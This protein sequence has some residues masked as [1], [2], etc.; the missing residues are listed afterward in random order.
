MQEQGKGRVAARLQPDRG[1]SECVLPQFCAQLRHLG[2]REFAPG[3]GRGVTLLHAPHQHPDEGGKSGFSSKPWALPSIAQ[4]HRLFGC[5]GAFIWRSSYQ[6]WWLCV[7]QNPTIILGSQH[8][9]RTGVAC[10]MYRPVIQSVA[11][12]DWLLF[13]LLHCS[14]RGRCCDGGHGRPHQRPAWLG[15]TSTVGKRTRWLLSTTP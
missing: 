11:I 15:G 5:C 3:R 12:C 10:R 14:G 9:K 6:V 13:V 7:L 4:A 2:I 8:A 1:I